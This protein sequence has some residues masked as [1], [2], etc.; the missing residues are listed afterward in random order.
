MEGELG[1]VRLDVVVRRRRVDGWR[2]CG[3]RDVMCDSSS[4]VVEEEGTAMHTV[5]GSDKPGKVL[6][7]TL[8]LDAMLRCYGTNAA[9]YVILAVSSNFL[10]PPVAVE[11]RGSRL[12]ACQG[13]TFKSTAILNPLATTPIHVRYRCCLHHCKRLPS[14]FLTVL[15]SPNLV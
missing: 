9:R 12:R 5:G 15:I 3:R 6:S 8:I 14:L 7:R 4:F 1:T 2:A 13:L 10:G 11:R